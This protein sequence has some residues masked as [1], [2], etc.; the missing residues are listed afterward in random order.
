MDAAS[1]G[2]T[3][4]QPLE[5]EPAG[6]QNQPQTGP[7]RRILVA[8]NDWNVRRINAEVL[9]EFGYQVET[10][11]DGVAAWTHLQFNGYDLLITNHD[12]PRVTGFE[13]LH[14]MRAAHMM[15]P[16]IFATRKMPKE[17]FERLSGLQPTLVLLQPFTTDEFLETVKMVLHMTNNAAIQPPQQ[18][19][20]Q[21]Q[22]TIARWES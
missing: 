9:I 21:R 16:V 7:R 4:P 2:K 8:D 17:E 14:R 5:K 1:S 6:A 15:L 3:Q 11:E 20:R 13:L 22:P 10:A 19:N 18:R 12:M